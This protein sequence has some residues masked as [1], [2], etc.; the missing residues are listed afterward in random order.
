[1]RTSAVRDRASAERSAPLMR[2]R[3]FLRTGLAGL[4]L[5]R[6]LALRA[7]AGTSASR[8]SNGP[9]RGLASGW[10]EPPGDLRPEARRAGRNPRPVR[11]DRHQ[12]RGGADQRA[13]AAS[14]RDGR[15]VRDPSV[16]VAL[17][18][19]PSAGQPADVHGA[20]GTGAQAQTRAPRLDVRRAPRAVRARAAG[21]RRTSA[22]TRSPT[23]ARPTSDRLSSRSASSATPTRPVSRSPE[24]ASPIRPRSPG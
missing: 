20:P 10:C 16:A 3:E 1:M 6:L 8:R 21:F 23:S 12:G 9:H 4:S 5:P 17:G 7:K 19:L 13:V 22:S 2:R 18:V 14:R 11:V 15:Q 24:S